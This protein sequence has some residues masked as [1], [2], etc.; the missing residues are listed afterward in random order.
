MTFQTALLIA[1]FAFLFA[2]FRELSEHGK[3]GGF[4]GWADWWNTP[5]SHRNKYTFGPDWLPRWVFGSALVWLTDA[6]HFFQF[7]SL[8][9]L[10]AIVLTLG[11]WELVLIAYLGQAL[12]GLLKSFTSI[13]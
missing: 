9:S 7:L 3:E 10:L 11:S 5:V 2:A 1:L 4:I 12:A 6:E 8:I 13:K